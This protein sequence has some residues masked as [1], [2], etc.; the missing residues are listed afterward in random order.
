MSNK[1]KPCTLAAAL[2]SVLVII[3]R[4][5][6]IIVQSAKTNLVPPPDTA[7]PVPAVSRNVRTV[8]L[9]VGHDKQLSNC[10]RSFY[11]SLIVLLTVGNGCPAPT[12]RPQCFFYTLIGHINV[13]LAQHRAS[14]LLLLSVLHC[15]HPSGNGC[16]A[17]LP[18]NHAVQGVTTRFFVN[19]PSKVNNARVFLQILSGYEPHLVAESGDTKW[20]VQLCQHSCLMEGIGRSTRQAYS[21]LQPQRAGWVFSQARKQMMKPVE[22]LSD[23]KMRESHTKP[24]EFEEEAEA[25]VGTAQQTLSQ[26]IEVKENLPELHEAAKFEGRKATRNVQELPLKGEQAL[27]MSTSTMNSQSS[28]TEELQLTIYD[29]GSTLEWPMAS[30]QK[31]ETDEGEHRGTKGHYMD[32]KNVKSAA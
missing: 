19:D 16:I 14:M 3:A 6:I 12:G 1:T 5:Y 2:S 10:E 8:V 31:A 24:E 29:L 17:I 15:S 32:T 13:I 22:A 27:C 23:D 4:H 25:A 11:L 9:A 18:C 30:F 21:K 7:V 20:A 26:S 28:Y